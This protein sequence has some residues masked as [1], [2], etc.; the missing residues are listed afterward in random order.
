M[1][2][3]F[4]PVFAFPTLS[5][6]LLTAPSAPPSPLRAGVPPLARAVIRP[7]NACR[8][9]LVFQPIPPCVIFAVYPLRKM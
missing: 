5:H 8:S 6:N 4:D 2:R 9:R 1:S 3:G 7:R